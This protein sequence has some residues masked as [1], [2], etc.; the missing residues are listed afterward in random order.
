MLDQLSCTTPPSAPASIS[1]SDGQYANKITVTW[2][3]S[4]SAASYKVYRSTELGGTYLEIATGLTVLTYNDTPIVASTHY[5]YKV[6]GVNGAGE[7]ALSVSD[8]GYTPTPPSAPSSVT[9]TNGTTADMVVITW[10]SVGT[11]GYYNVYRSSSGRDLWQNQF[12]LRYLD[13]L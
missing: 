5:F 8:E 3:A 6:S 10:S 7:G 13:N 9:A 12:I 2:S 4:A 11:A 1:A